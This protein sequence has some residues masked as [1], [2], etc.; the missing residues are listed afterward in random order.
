MAQANLDNARRKLTRQQQLASNK[1]D[2]ESG[3]ATEAQRD[4]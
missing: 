1:V 3:P 2:N 4:L